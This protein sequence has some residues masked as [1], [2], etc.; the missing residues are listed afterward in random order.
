MY[1]GE[2]NSDWKHKHLQFNVFYPRF[3]CFLFANQCF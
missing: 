3:L 2:K 1:N